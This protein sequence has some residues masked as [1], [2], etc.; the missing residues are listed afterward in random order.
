V[1]HPQLAR[2]EDKTK[3]ADPNS[4]FIQDAMKNRFGEAALQTGL[5]F[6][7]IA[8]NIVNAAPKFDAGT[9]FGQPKPS[10]SVISQGHPYLRIGA[11]LLGAGSRAYANNNDV[12][13]H[14]LVRSVLGNESVARN[15]NEVA[16]KVARSAAK[17]A[18]RQPENVKA[19]ND[20]IDKPD[21][22]QNSVLQKGLGFISRQIPQQVKET[23]KE[24]YRSATAKG[25]RTYENGERN[26]GNDA[27][28][29]YIDALRKNA[30][31]KD[32]LTPEL[33]TVSGQIA[34]PAL[35]ALSATGLPGGVA[36]LAYT[37]ANVAKGA[38]TGLSI[39]KDIETLASNKPWIPKSPGFWSFFTNAN[40]KNRADAIGNIPVEDGQYDYYKNMLEEQ[41]KSSW[42]NRFMR[43]LGR[44]NVDGLGAY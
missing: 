26:Y 5:V 3:L 11:G 2:L 7:P 4:Q 22:G 17:R 25:G 8:A 27:A 41:R 40:A 1:Q 14:E 32:F 38:N 21:V 18:V 10:F 42:W 29:R 39:K 19:V 23:A 33:G 34:S 9:F 12:V 37:G 15:L 35:A 44:T 16:D 13:S 20:F 30:Q 28:Y 24:T 31:D 36:N 43:T 6:S